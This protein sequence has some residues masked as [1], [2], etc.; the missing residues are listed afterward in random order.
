MR[1]LLCSLAAVGL[2]IGL[3]AGPA[4]AAPG[5]VARYQV[6]TDQYTLTYV[7]YIHY[8]T[9][10][11]NPCDRTIAMS[12]ATPVD[13][14]YYTTETISATLA[15]GVISLVATYDG[16]YSP[17]FIWAGSFPVGGGTLTGTVPYAFT[18]SIV[19]DGTTSTDYRNHG[20]YVS[21]MGGGS[22]AAHSCI[23]MPM[24]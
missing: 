20:E 10:V 6:T 1:R 24:R 3:V 21:S 16:P 4:V 23:G 22:D 17:G 11:N 9:V 15:G 13:S 8:L 14:A 19:L 18:A 7:G 2:L 5:G 12:G